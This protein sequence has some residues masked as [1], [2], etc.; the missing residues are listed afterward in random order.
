MLIGT[1]GEC[2]AKLDRW[3]AA[4]VD[5]PI[6]TMPTGSVD[7]TAAQLSALKAALSETPVA[8]STLG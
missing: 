1:A 3:V 5:E 8:G 7:E 2:V 4:G 6:L